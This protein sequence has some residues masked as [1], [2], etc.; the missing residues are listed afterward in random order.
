MNLHRLLIASGLALSVVAAS[1]RAEPLSGGRFSLNGGPVTGAGQSGGG[2]FAVAGAPGET[3]TGPLSGGS[4]RVIGGLVGVA[5]VPGDFALTIDFTADGQ[6]RIGWP[7]EATGYVLEF[8]PSVG[9][10]ANWQPV[11]PAPAGNSHTTP[12]D[13]PLRFFRLNR[14]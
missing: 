12:H 5:V 3:A 11:T 10:F 1:L 4:F 6:A 13:Q 8:T 2:T 14:P 9:E 7:A